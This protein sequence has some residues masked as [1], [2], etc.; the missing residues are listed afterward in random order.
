MGCQI[1]QRSCLSRTPIV[2]V[3]YCSHWTQIPYLSIS[4]A[5]NLRKL[6]IYRKRQ[7]HQLWL[8]ACVSVFSYMMLMTLRVMLCL[9][10]KQII[11]I[12]VDWCILCLLCS[13][14]YSAVNALAGH[15]NSFGLTAPVPKKRLDRI[16]KVKYALWALEMSACAPICTCLVRLWR[17]CT[18]Q[19]T[20]EE[21]CYS[22]YCML[23][24][25]TDADR[26]LKRGR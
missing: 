25:I 20:H 5:C 7:S 17:L 6:D 3:I 18:E 16:Q 10:T 4:R 14:T 1:P 21:V 24:E 26:A 13:T 15:F 11:E 2:Q 8:I 12:S 22:M 23:Q 19:V 9:S